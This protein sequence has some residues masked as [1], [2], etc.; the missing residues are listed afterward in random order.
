MARPLAILEAVNGPEELSGEVQAIEYRHKDDG[1]NYRHNFGPGVAMDAEDDGTV[2]LTHA[3]GRG[4][5]RDHSGQTF[6][7]N[8]PKKGGRKMARRLPPRHRSGPKKGQFKK[9]NPT[10]QGRKSPRRAYTRTVGRAPYAL[11]A[12]PLRRRA[13]QKR[14]ALYRAP[15]RRARPRPRALARPRRNPCGEGNNNYTMN[16]PRMTFRN[17]TKTLMD[18]AMDSA[19]VLTGKAATR[20]IP[21]MANLPKEGNIGLAVQG[22][23]A[24]V[25]S[26]LAQ[27]FLRPAQ[28]RMILAGGLTAPLETLIVSFNVPFLAPA[29]QPVEA[30]AQLSAYLGGY[31]SPPPPAPT[32]GA[33]EGAVGGYVDDGMGAYGDSWAYA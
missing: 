24:V 9:R 14:A 1:I 8:P 3:G 13:P 23:T 20:A 11:G 5:H 7:I 15:A 10:H 30:D 26:M 31:V 22:L 12:A 25:I 32:N 6:L 17:I 27:N 28:A 4:L 18:G 29:L 21:L 19:L 2:R 16:A 33:V